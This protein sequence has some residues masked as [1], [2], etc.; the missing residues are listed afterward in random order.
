MEQAIACYQQTQLAYTE[1]EFPTE[2]AGTQNNLSA[3]YSDRI[4]GEHHANLEEAIAY[5]RAA[6]RVNQPETFPYDWAWTL[7]NPGN[8]YSD[9]VLGERSAFLV[10]KARTW[11][12]RS[13]AIKTRSRSIPTPVPQ[14][15]GPEQHMHDE[16][17]YAHPI[18]WAGFQIIGW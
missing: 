7:L 16:R 13:P 8:A 18:Y 17:P 4:A 12:A 10:R 6:L 9:R 3:A 2:W 5:A 14:R 11:N 1:H 15:I